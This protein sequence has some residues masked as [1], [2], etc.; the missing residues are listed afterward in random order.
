MLRRT[1][2]TT[3][4]LKIYR[5]KEMDTMVVMTMLLRALIIFGAVAGLGL[6]FKPLLCGLARALMLYLRPRPGTR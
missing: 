3:Q 4:E 5:K 1:M 6:F 2:L